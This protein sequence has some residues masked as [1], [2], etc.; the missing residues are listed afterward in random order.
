ML[1]YFWTYIQ[2]KLCLY[3]NM[4][5]NFVR[6]HYNYVDMQLMLY[7]SIRMCE[8]LVD[9]GVLYDKHNNVA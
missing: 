1:M 7:L 3:V 9:M 6:I 8:L 5:A 4:R 2:D